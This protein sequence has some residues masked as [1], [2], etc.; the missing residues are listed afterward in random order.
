ML[1][2]DNFKK[3]AGRAQVEKNIKSTIR[4]KLRRVKVPPRI[5]ALHFS[6]MEPY[7]EGEEVYDSEDDLSHDQHPC[8]AGRELQQMGR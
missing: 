1:F 4:S 8:V 2:G 6:T 3:D 5:G 7:R